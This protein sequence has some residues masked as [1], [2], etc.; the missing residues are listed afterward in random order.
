MLIEFSVQNFCSV[1]DSVTLTFMP[2]PGF[3]NLSELYYVEPTEGMKLLKF[4]AILGANASGKT[5]LLRALEI[6]RTL[7]CDPFTNK[8]RTLSF[9]VPYWFGENEGEPTELSIKFVADATQ[10]HYVVSFNSKSIVEERLRIKEKTWH[11]V[12][13]RT[14]VPSSQT[15]KIRMGVN[16]AKYRR[17]FQQLESVTLWNNTVLGGSQKVSFNIPVLQTAVEWF[18]GYLFPLIGPETNL[19]GFVC[20]LVDRGLVDKKRL[21]QYLQGAD[22]MI[23]DFQLRH[24]SWE[25]LDEKLRMQLIE[26]NPDMSLEEIKQRFPMGHVVFDHNNG[27]SS[28]KVD[29]SDESL[30]TQRFY[31]LCGVLDMLLHRQCMFF[32]DEIDSS[33]HPDLLEYLLITFLVNSR[34]SQ[35]LISTHHREW[36]MREDFV[37]PDSIWFTEKNRNGST[38]LYSLADFKGIN[39]FN[40]SFS[41]Y[42]AYRRGVLGAMPSPRNYY[43]ESKDNEI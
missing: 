38:Q 41:Y 14:T 15:V 29:Y 28:I 3:D 11:T 5:T 18:Q 34:E 16:Y 36:L 35:L 26:S 30:G 40:R 31:Q 27:D 24:D 23:S 6:L 32:I 9:Y 12:Y 39:S 37:R 2:T 8:T 43:I 21:L 22:M 19:Y 10:F 17:D 7:T 33:I 13:H 1:S 20:N 4:G 42:D 25:N